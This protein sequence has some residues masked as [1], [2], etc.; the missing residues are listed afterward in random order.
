MKIEET[1]AFLVDEYGLDENTHL[2]E[3]KQTTDYPYY[4]ISDGEET[5][6]LFLDLGGHACLDDVEDEGELEASFL[7]TGDYLFSVIENDNKFIVGF[8][9]KSEWDT[10]GAF[11]DQQIGYMLAVLYP[12]IP[13]WV[14]RDE[15]SE[16]TFY[17]GDPHTR[18]EIIDVLTKAGLIHSPDMDKLA[19][20]CY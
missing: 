3:E 11:W 7:P 10:D 15:A 13:S 14:L 1:I 8:T 19:E 4:V 6:Y 12:D 20:E 18:E 17:I 16:N 9:P 5:Q 2:V